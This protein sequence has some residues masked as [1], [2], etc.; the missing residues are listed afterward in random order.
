MNSFEKEFDKLYGDLLWLEDS[1]ISND[2]IKRSWE[3]FYDAVEKFQSRAE[4]V[5]NVKI[6]R[7]TDRDQ[8]SLEL[9]EEYYQLRLMLQSVNGWPVRHKCL[10][11]GR[12]F[13]SQDENTTTC[14]DCR[15]KENR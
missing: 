1:I 5:L 13:V 11:C 7:L 10:H 9:L 15:P 6:N 12:K 4:Q 14:F 8:D 3:S 2:K